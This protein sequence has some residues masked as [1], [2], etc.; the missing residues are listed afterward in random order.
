MANLV[1]HHSI[2]HVV[3]LGDY[4]F[5]GFLLMEAMNLQSFQTLENNISEVLRS[6]R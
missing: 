1:S 3:W 6:S 4:H 2:D 5:M